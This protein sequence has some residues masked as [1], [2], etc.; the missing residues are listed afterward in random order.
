MFNELTAKKIYSELAKARQILLITH[1]ST[2]GD[3][4]GAIS[5]LAQFLT[6]QSKS[7]VIFAKGPLPTNLNFLPFFDELK[8]DPQIL[9][10]K[11]FDLVVMLDTS[12]LRHTGVADILEKILGSGATLINIDHHYTNQQ[13]GSFNL[14]MPEASSTSEVLYNF[15]E[16]NHITLDKSIATALLTGI[17][18]D[19]ENFS[20]PGTT[21]KAL[22]AAARLVSKGGQFNLITRRV[23]RQRSINILKVWGRVLARLSINPRTGI[24]KTIIVQDDLRDWEIDDEAVEGISNFLNNVEGV[25]FSLVLKEKND[26]TLRGSLRTTRDDVDVAKLALILG[27]GGH[28]KAAGFTVKAVLKKDEKNGWYV[29]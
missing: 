23:F 13:I 7:F 29:E 4:V 25:K 14:V 2:D 28:R 6:R 26:G 18:T 3:A 20:N 8:T 15:F 10:D 11:I 1:Q 19:T 12:D 9:A 22:K 16:A 27:G 5:A 24:A 17:I 21:D